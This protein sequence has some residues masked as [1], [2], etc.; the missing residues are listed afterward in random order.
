MYTGARTVV[1]WINAAA[2]HN[3]PV[4]TAVGQTDY[5]PLGGAPMMAIGPPFHRGDVGIRKTWNT[6]QR[7]RLEFRAEFFNITNT[8]NFTIPSNLNFGNTVNFGE[9]AATRD[10]PNDPREIQFA[11]KFFF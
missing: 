5:A 1:H 9:I 11:L 8:P 3:P 10:N 4:A 2:F 6:S 7:T